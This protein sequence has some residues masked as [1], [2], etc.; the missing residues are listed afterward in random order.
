VR[1]SLLGIVF[2]MSCAASPP[3]Q[4]PND[5]EKLYRKMEAALAAAKKL[6]V[7]FTSTTEGSTIQGSFRV[8]EGN[9]LKM[10]IEGAAGAKTY[11]ITLSCDGAQMSLTR[12]ESPP[13][14]V[15]LGPQPAL[16][17]P[18]T[19]TA[20][21]AA[22]LARGG[23]WLAQEFAD[24]EYRAV[25]D[26]YFEER[27]KAKEQENRPMNKLPAVA[28]RDV[29]AL[30]TMEN[31][32][33]GKSEGGASA[34]TYDLVRKGGKPILINTMTVWIDSKTGLPVKRE[35]LIFAATDEG[36][37]AGAPVSKQT[38]TYKITSE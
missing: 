17:A 8:D 34:V 16:P 18:K 13:P 29:T 26:P 36:K 24:G 19:L 5:G 32:R 2:A 11:K 1:S 31:F 7:D 21:V 6:H 38:E 27:Q 30:H 3:Y 14:P 15:P 10:E 25:A 28:P 12:S 35:S 37:V 20:N 33:P 4:A 23:A 9:K 22:A